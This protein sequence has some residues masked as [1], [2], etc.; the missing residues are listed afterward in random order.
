M[1]SLVCS[2][3]YQ[4]ETYSTCVDLQGGLVFVVHLVTAKSSESSN[5]VKAE[6]GILHL[7]CT[8]AFM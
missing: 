4:K 7:I 8:I 3:Y 5:Y 6:A 2:T 1:K